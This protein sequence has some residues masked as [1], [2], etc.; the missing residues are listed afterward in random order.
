MLHLIQIYLQY[1]GEY[2]D[3]LTPTMLEVII[4]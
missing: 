4:K 2:V 3:I 1:V